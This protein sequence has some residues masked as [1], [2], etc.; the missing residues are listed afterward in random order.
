MRANIELDDTLVQ[1]MVATGQRIRK[2]PIEE[3][4]R[5][6]VRAYEQR[7]AIEDLRGL[8]WEGDLDEMRA[9]R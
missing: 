3:A 7:Q 9:D 2:G 5:R 1:P 4:L 8:G 6:L